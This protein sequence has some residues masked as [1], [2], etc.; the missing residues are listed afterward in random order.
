[1][2]KVYLINLKDIKEESIIPLNTDEK[3]LEIALKEVTHLELENLVS[4]EYLE[5]LSDGVI[6]KNLEQKDKDVIRDYIKP[7]LIYGTIFFAIPYL[8]NKLNNKGVNVSTDATLI[9]SAPKVVD[10][11]Q[12]LVS[13]RFDSYKKRL[14]DYFHTDSDDETD[15]NPLASTTSS[16]LNF[17]LPDEIDRSEQYYKARASKTNYRGY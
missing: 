11:F 16:T 4:K 7:F 12:Q 6:N 14:I 3:I 15:S 17:Y 1:M 8:H 9:A 10:S 13:Q 5:K 2:A